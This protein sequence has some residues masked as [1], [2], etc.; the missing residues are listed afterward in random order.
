VTDYDPKIETRTK[1]GTTWVRFEHVS[2]PDWR[3]RAGH[4]PGGDVVL[5]AVAFEMSE[6]DVD[7]EL[8]RD[9]SIVFR[10]RNGRIFVST[11]WLADRFPDCGPTLEVVTETVRRA[12]SIGL[13]GG[14]IR[15]SRFP[16]PGRGG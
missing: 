14:Y 9:R 8:V 4:L 13:A 5:P 15:E 16:A 2:G 12:V 10:R 11:D 3:K 1:D 6:P 7:D